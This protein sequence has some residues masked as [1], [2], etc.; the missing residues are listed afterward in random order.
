[1]CFTVCCA[2]RW[3]DCLSA[4]LERLQCRQPARRS[5]VRIRSGLAVGKQLTPVLESGRLFDAHLVK[6]ISRFCG[7]GREQADS[8]KVVWLNWRDFGRHEPGF[9]YN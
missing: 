2:G 8:T 5:L 3:I 1:L 4:D 7:G 9:R 6:R